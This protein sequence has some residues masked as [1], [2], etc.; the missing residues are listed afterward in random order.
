[1]KL[2]DYQETGVDF[3]CTRGPR[4]YLA[5][6]MGLGKTAQAVTA[7]RRLGIRSP[8]IVAPAS[9]VSNWHREWVK[10]WPDS[11]VPDVVSYNYLTNHPEI[12][13][14]SWPLLILDEAHYAKTP[15][16]KRTRAS[17]RAAARAD[18]AWLLSGTPMPNDPRELYPA[19]KHLWPEMIPE[20]AQS[21]EGWRIHFCKCIPSVYGPK[22]VGVKNGDQLRQMLNAVML[23]RD[24]SDV[25]L[26]LPPL[27]VHLQTL[28][29]D[30]ELARKLKSIEAARGEALETAT[31]RRL[32]GESKRTPV[33]DLL[34][35][36]LED[37]AYD[38]VVLMYHHRETGRYLRYKLEASGAVC[39]GFDGSTPLNKRQPEIDKFQNGES[40]VFLVQQQA[41]GVG[42][43]LTRA[44]E[45]VLLEP[46][47][48]PEVN[49][50]AI[51]RCHRIGQDAPV[52]AR[53]FS[54]MG[55][56][57]EAIMKAIVR[58]INMRR[59]VL[60]G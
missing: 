32:L 23:R 4:L 21:A 17:L 57:D 26:E 58:K 45:I 35:R 41:G 7:A 39:S 46:D 42:I 54:V 1:M 2:Y 56:L 36:E 8:L 38:S 50:Q 52:R 20:E 18:Q 33:S 6:R 43:N 59:E 55:S 28:P 19:F 13:Q 12:V 30:R 5:D 10:W 27:R 49:A 14:G 3:L 60:D 47:W 11:N 25:G 31:V 29:P 53:V 16:A 15:S 40:N 37:K 24:L 48:S 44:S 22:V 9:V 34:L 51:K